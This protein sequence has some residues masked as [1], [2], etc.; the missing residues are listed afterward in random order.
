MADFAR[1]LVAI[2]LRAADPLVSADDV[3]R[4]VE[5]W[6]R[7]DPPSDGRVRYRRT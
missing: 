7:S 3:A 1:E 5:Q 6:L 4:A 2:R